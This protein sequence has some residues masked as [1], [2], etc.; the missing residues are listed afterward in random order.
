MKRYYIKF[1]IVSLLIN[2]KA[3]STDDVTNTQRVISSNEIITMFGQP[4]TYKKNTGSSISI[5]PG[6]IKTNMQCGQIQVDILNNF[7]QALSDL[8]QMPQK[9]VNQFGSNFSTLVAASPI[10]AL[11]YSSPTLCAELKNLNLNL[12]QDIGLQT[13][14][15]QSIDTYVT[16]RADQGRKDAYDRTLK[17]CIS[18]YSGSMGVRN[19]TYKCNKD[20]SENN[21]LVA[22]VANNTVR[23]GVVASQNIIHSA[24][25]AGGAYLTQNDKDRYHLLKSSLGDM[26]LQANGSIV[27][28]FGNLK[29]TPNDINENILSNSQNIVCD[30]NSLRRATNG[31]LNISATYDSDLYLQN[32]LSA[33]IKKNL[34]E[35]DVSNLEDL[36]FV[37]RDVI[38]NALSRS[39]SSEVVKIIISDNSN[40]L[41][42]VTNNAV[43]PEDVKNSI[44]SKS[45]EF[46]NSLKKSSNNESLIPLPVIKK[47]LSKLAFQSRDTKRQIGVA[48]SKGTVLEASKDMNNCD[49]FVTCE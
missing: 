35:I 49:S 9:L 41:S 19:A 24:L 13:N 32:I 8:K 31:N 1:V 47:Q 28:A 18:E 33:T 23:N 5:N 29:M 34:S 46:F 22:D 37:D 12:Q 6:N 39:L 15:C 40:A 38:C 26:Q 2:F 45:N 43:I 30:L 36:D 25:T 17:S 10:L 21:V 4:Q 48:L 42:N 14:I 3:Y 44:I 11:C 20:V 7:N 27:P 16:D